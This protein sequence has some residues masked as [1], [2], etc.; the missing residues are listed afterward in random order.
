VID[1]V[2]AGEGMG[3]HFVDEVKMD[4]LIASDDNLAAD[5]VGASVMGYD[6]HEVT[7][8]IFAREK[9]GPSSRCSVVYMHDEVK[10]SSVLLRTGQTNVQVIQGHTCAVAFLW[11][12]FSFGKGND[13][14]R[15]K[16]YTFV[17]AGMLKYRKEGRD[18]SF[19]EIVRSITKTRGFLQRAVLPVQ[20]ICLIHFSR[21]FSNF[22]RR[23]DGKV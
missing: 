3:P 7:M 20:R 4:L 5:I 12:S 21:I 2:T 8:R 13:L 16:G 6:P 17:M 11:P 14:D 23:S 22:E 10:A 15:I 18:S 1:A 19:W 9:E